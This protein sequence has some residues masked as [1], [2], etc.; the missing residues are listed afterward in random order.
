M[1]LKNLWDREDGFHA[2]GH[3]SLNPSVEVTAPDEDLQGDQR[4]RVIGQELP[5]RSSSS[6]LPEA[7][8]PRDVPVALCSPRKGLVEAV[9][10]S[11]RWSVDKSNMEKQHLHHQHDVR[12]H[13][14]GKVKPGAEPVEN[15][16][17]DQYGE[18][19]DTNG[20]FSLMTNFVIE[21]TSMMRGMSRE[22]PADECFRFMLH[23][24]SPYDVTGEVTM[25]T[26]AM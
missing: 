22:N 11:E 21:A 25:N 13:Q 18:Q 7:V 24:W 19:L 10:G 6:P 5:I 17:P 1:V 20:V 14:Q 26:G 23:I 9:L 2:Q 12:L 8:W 4:N 15:S 16:I 3:V